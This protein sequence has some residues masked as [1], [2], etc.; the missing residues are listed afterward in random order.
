M[1]ANEKKRMI[2][3][4]FNTVAAGYDNPALPFF[5]TTAELLLEHLNLDN[6]DTLL[7]VCTGTGAVALRAAKICPQGHVTGIDLSPGM[8]EQAQ[9]RAS[10]FE[11]DNVTFLEMDIEQHDLEPDRFDAISCSFGL[12][13][14]DDMQSAL[15]K[16]VSSLKP[17]GKLAISSFCGSAFEPCSSLFLDRYAAMGKEVPALSWKRLG[18]TELINNLFDKAGLEQ[19]HIHHEPLGHH[20]HCAEDWW[21][22]VWN[23]GYRGLLNTLDDEQVIA[24]KRQHIAEIG[25]LCEVEPF[26][27]NTEIFIASAKKPA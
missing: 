6:R 18:E 9:R 19:T 25:A 24:F 26:W 27:L 4:A 8:L 16:L 12:F 2:R 15:D 22:I 17:G 10:E 11:L 13:F 1:D 21:E 3:E 20:L 14:I 23:A 5:P 7:D